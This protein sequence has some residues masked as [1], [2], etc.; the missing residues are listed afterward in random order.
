M[1]IYIWAPLRNKP[2]YVLHKSKHHALKIQQ[3]VL[4]MPSAFW[5]IFKELTNTKCTHI[6]DCAFICIK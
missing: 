5:V 2:M 4:V 1:I 6:K 3:W